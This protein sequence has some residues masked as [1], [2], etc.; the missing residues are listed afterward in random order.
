MA[1]HAVTSTFG[2][3]I[4]VEKFISEAAYNSFILNEAVPP[5]C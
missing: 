2:K 3:F 1:K 4:L 5:Y